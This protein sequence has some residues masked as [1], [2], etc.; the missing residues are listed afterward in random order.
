[1]KSEAQP[2]AERKSDRKHRYLKRLETFWKADA[3]NR[4]KNNEGSIE[5][6]VGGIDP[7]EVGDHEINWN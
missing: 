6:I 7:S 1:M 4:R 2:S 3:Q 5:K